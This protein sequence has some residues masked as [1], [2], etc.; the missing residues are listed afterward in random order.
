MQL[1]YLLSTSLA[2]TV[3]RRTSN[4]SCPHYLCLRQSWPTLNS[5]LL[6][7]RYIGGLKGIDITKIQNV[8]RYNI[9]FID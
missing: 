8:L 9:F 7:T 3:S 5:F 1:K 4:T 6:I 2:N